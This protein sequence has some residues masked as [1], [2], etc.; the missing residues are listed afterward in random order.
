MV[1]DTKM[2]PNKSIKSSIVKHVHMC[3]TIPSHLACEMCPYILQ[4]IYTAPLLHVKEKTIVPNLIALAYWKLACD[5]IYLRISLLGVTNNDK[6]N[7]D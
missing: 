7:W 3:T 6:S 4:V 2:F 5:P 1:L